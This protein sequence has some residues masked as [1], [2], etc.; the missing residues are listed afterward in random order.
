[1][2]EVD[3]RKGAKTQRNNEQLCEQVVSSSCLVEIEHGLLRTINEKLNIWNQ[4][5]ACGLQ[6]LKKTRA[7]A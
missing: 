5:A 1:M 4:A 6:Q 7:E 3:S 2:K